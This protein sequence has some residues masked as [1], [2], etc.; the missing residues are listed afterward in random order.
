[1]SGT[2]LVLAYGAVQSFYGRPGKRMFWSSFSISSWLYFVL[3]FIRPF[4]SLV[5]PYLI[6]TRVLAIAWRSPGIAQPTS[7]NQIPIGNMSAERYNSY[8]P[9]GMYGDSNSLEYL[10]SIESFFFVGHSM[11]TLLIGFCFAF[12]CVLLASRSSR[13]SP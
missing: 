5:A 8:S 1:M 6:T 10:E 7:S 4:V 11:F 13:F 9:D 3:A 12:A 2:L